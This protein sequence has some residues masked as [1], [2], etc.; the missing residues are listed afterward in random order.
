M[1]VVG[2]RAGTPERPSVTIGSP[3]FTKEGADMRPWNR[4]L[5]AMAALLILTLTAC[6]GDD[7][8]ADDTSHESSADQAAPDQPAPN[9]PDAEQTGEDA[10][11]GGG[12]AAAD[13][14]DGI[15]LDAGTALSANNVRS[16]LTGARV[17]RDA[18][19]DIHVAEFEP[20]WD[21]LRRI[22]GDVGGYVA[23]ASTDIAAAAVGAVPDDGVCPEGDC[24][25]GY[26]VGSATLRVPSARFDE[27]MDRVIALGEPISQAVQGTDVSEEFVDL[28]AR[29]RHW[30][31]V[32]VFTL[33]LMDDAKDIADSLAI[34]QRLD[35]VQLTIE[36]IEGRLRFLDARTTFS[37]IT[38]GLTEAPVVPP[39]PVE[40]P[41]PAPITEAFQQA[42]DMITA[43]LA[44]M[45][46]ALAFIVP[47][48]VIGAIGLL[49]YRL[50]RRNRP[51]Q[52]EET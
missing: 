16:D 7:D 24:N 47:F 25:D 10:S 5:A 6:A 39:A 11:D 18:T 12:A 20:A 23:D 13:G 3:V 50:V 43:V 36:Q 31:R 4:Y 27:A 52:V 21:R 34:Q 15:A 2:N 38:V 51:R 1:G 22:A 42:V 37:T 40:T 19:I 49:G 9:Q 8:S 32:E 48:G 46:V 45:I 26:A 44:F 17:I 29:L 28:E 14:D 30:K 41:E 35:T 33:G